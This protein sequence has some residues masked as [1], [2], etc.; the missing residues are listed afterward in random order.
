MAGVGFKQIQILA[1]QKTV[2]MTAR[3]AH[4][5]PNTLH[6][7]VELITRSARKTIKSW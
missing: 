5:S 6:S 1:G 7:A 4:L 2:A 3:Y